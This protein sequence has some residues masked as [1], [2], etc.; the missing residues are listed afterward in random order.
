MFGSRQNWRFDLSDG[1]LGKCTLEAQLSTRWSTDENGMVIGVRYHDGEL[2]QLTYSVEQLTFVVRSV[3][4]AV[5]KVAVLAL[6]DCRI[7]LWGGN[8][9][10]DIFYW[11]VTQAPIGLPVRKEAWTNLWHG[12]GT[13]DGQLEQEIRTV[14]ERCPN[15]KLLHVEFSY[16]GSLTA[17]AAEI[18]FDQIG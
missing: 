15:G 3:D 17:L 13:P 11:P 14:G 18:T 10:S 9:V 7:E 8:I 6:L 4:A 1:R 5:L 16:G 12:R 2:Q